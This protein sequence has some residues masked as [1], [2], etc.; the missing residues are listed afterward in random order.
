MT[1]PPGTVTVVETGNV[2]LRL[3]GDADR[4]LDPRDARALGEQLIEAATAASTARR[5]EIEAQIA[6]LQAEL[7]EFGVESAGDALGHRLFHDGTE[8]APWWVETSP[9]SGR[10]LPMSNNE[11]L[12]GSGTGD[13]ADS[14][15]L[16]SLQDSYGSDLVEHASLPHFEI[17]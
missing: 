2:L 14:S 10:Y 7:K 3:A 16:H 5:A 12:R 6:E 1:V 15:T 13:Y 4:Y 11:I 17:Y 8:C 9:G